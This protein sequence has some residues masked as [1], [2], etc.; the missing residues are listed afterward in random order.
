M[1]APDR[2]AQPL[3][4]QQQSDTQ[5][6]ADQQQPQQ[7]SPTNK[8]AGSVL[9]G[10]LPSTSTFS[11]QGERRPGRHCT[12]TRWAI[13]LAALMLLVVAGVAAG[14]GVA[15]SKRKG[16]RGTQPVS[17]LRCCTFLP[18]LLH[19]LFPHHR[20]NTVHMIGW[21]CVLLCCSPGRATRSGCCR[22]AAINL[23]HTAG[24]Q[25]CKPKSLTATCGR[26]QNKPQPGALPN[27]CKPEPITTSSRQQPFP[28]AHRHRKP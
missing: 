19:C 11:S 23:T 5:Q 12:R 16:K 15:L 26:Q 4:Q 1:S 6:A 13:A 8:D 18:T 2:A 17:L 3:L 24:F 21:L 10:P 27:I 9:I 20:L 25:H 7:D 14:V 28:S 22:S